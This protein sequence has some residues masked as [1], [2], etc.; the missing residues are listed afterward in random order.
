M[1]HSIRPHFHPIP[2]VMTHRTA[3]PAVAA[4]V[5]GGVRH[6]RRDVPVGLEEGEKVDKKNEAHTPQKK[7]LY[8]TLK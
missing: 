6:A 1:H 8:K 3:N 4:V 2:R 5:R 7:G